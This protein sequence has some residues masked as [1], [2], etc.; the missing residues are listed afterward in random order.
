ML[1]SK[2][3]T[4]FAACVEYDGSYYKGW[5]SQVGVRTVQDDLEA[6]LS[7]I[8]DQP[9]R[10][11]AAGR[12]DTAV[13]ATGQI[14]HFEGP[15]ER[16]I[17]AWFRG[18]NTRLGAGVALRWVKAVDDT[19]HA[20]FSAQSR[21]YRYILLNQAVRP[22]LFRNQVSWEYRP[23]AIKPMTDAA[24]YLLGRHDFSA[25]RASSCQSRDPVKTLSEVTLRQS[26]N[27]IWLDIEANGFLHHMVR[28]IMGVLLTIGKGQQ[29]ASWCKTVL[30]SL[31][32][33]QGGM[34]APPHG[35]YLTHVGYDE[36]YQLPDAEY[37]PVF[38]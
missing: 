20:R 30:E 6:A 3:K 8:A 9:I 29:P 24:A 10:V 11:I 14:V 19:F 22:A 13:H 21:R 26:G 33:R 1:K 28:N 4:R 27:W 37:R 32:R 34:T 25:Y 36:K 12:T 35:L 18:T 7:K 31:D 2:A 16:S 15:A 23:L 5:Q 38:W 17:D